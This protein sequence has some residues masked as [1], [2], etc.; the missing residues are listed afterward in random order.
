MIFSTTFIYVL[1][2]TSL[3]ENIAPTQNV[4]DSYSAMLDEIMI[5]EAKLEQEQLRSITNLDTATQNEIQAF[6]K[7]ETVKHE[8]ALISEVSQE[9]FAI[10]FFRYAI[11]RLFVAGV[12]FTLMRYLIRLFFRIRADRNDLIM[13][14]EALSTLFYVLDEIEIGKY[15][16][17]K[18][19]I[20][21][22]PLSKLF[23]S[24]ETVGRRRKNSDLD[25]KELVGGLNT[26]LGSQKQ[27]ISTL[28]E[29]TNQLLGGVKSKNQSKTPT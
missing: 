26:I 8:D 27:L 6:I 14:E 2:K 9:F 29:I 28:Q 24:S 19:K 17:L 10:Y 12:A 3:A 7:N 11:V 16:V 13:K 18:S 25:M 23:E 21:E 20:P 4:M 22:F 1:Y 5:V 15:D